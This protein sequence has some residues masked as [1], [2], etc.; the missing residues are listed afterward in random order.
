MGSEV[1][2]SGTAANPIELSDSSDEEA[3]LEG[4][5]QQHKI[6][7]ATKSKQMAAIYPLKRIGRS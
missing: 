3:S 2:A 7:F 5:S 6:E 1:G 4:A